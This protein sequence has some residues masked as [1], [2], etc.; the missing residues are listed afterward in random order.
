M[1]IAR[2]FS[3]WQ[4]FASIQFRPS[5]RIHFPFMKTILS[6]LFSTAVFLSSALA[7]V[8]QL[9]DGTYK[10][11][12]MFAFNEEKNMLLPAA[13]ENTY[14]EFRI[15]IFKPSSLD[16]P[17]IRELTTPT[18]CVFKV[19]GRPSISPESG[20]QLLLVEQIL[21]WEGAPGESAGN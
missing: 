16:Y 14:G 2:A 11:T 18:Q 21:E 19:R 5:S 20:D 8:E 6:I 9:E 12:G 13:K 3:F 17:G 1:R 7:D 10:V 4:N 15:V